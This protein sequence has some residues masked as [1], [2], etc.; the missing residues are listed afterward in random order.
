MQ[1]KRVEKDYFIYIEKNEKVM[2]ILTQF[3]V[4]QKILNERISGFGAV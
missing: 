4:D 2:D 1:Y 3:C